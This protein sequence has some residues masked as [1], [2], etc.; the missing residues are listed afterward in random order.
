M[1]LDDILVEIMT[2]VTTSD[3]V[4]A[5]HDLEEGGTDL[6]EGGT[7]PER[8]CDRRGCD[9]GQLLGARV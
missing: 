1:I 9:T 4:E 5:G 2:I 8:G 6:G 7:D 3:P